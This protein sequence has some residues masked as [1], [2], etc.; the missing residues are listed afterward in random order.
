MKNILLIAKKECVRFFSDKRLVFAAI[1]LPG[2]M[3]FGL[4][5]FMGYQQQNAASTE[6]Y[7]ILAVDMPASVR[8][9]LT[10][11]EGVSISDRNAEESANAKMEIEAE[12]ADLLML[13]SPDFDE[14]VAV[15]SVAQ[16]AHVPHIELFYNSVN[17]HS[18]S[19]Y[20]TVMQYLT[21]Y[22]TTLVNKFDINSDADTAYDVSTAGKR[23][24][25]QYATLI[26]MFLLLCIFMGSIQIT[27]ESIAGEKERG[28]LASLL[29]TPIRHTEL[30]CGKICSLSLLSMLSGLSG[31]IGSVCALPYVFNGARDT[32]TASMYTAGDFC[33]LLLVICSA[34][35]LIVSVITLV[36]AIS[37][38]VRVAQSYTTPIML[39]SSLSSIATMFSTGEHSR[40]V[41]VIPIYNISQC[42]TDI[43][44]LEYDPIGIL[45]TAAINIF[46]SILLACGTVK[47]LARED[48]VFPH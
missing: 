16:S 32:L 29:I 6:A 22:E 11:I 3:I 17:T 15:Y 19:V 42:F 8:T 26:P 12:T 34:V 4:Y 9:V 33:V 35:V 27:T 30:I 36:S 31:F 20:T 21:A 44:S 40:S 23:L 7:R 2:L 14:Q 10:E 24:T 47:L 5:A 28:T 1:L 37:P 39:L 13:F 46:C 38:S 25:N 43:I 45:V 18:V 41:Y 48:V